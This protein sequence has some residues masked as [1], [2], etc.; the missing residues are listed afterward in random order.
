MVDPFEI[1]R[2]FEEELRRQF[3][4]DK[5]LA[6]KCYTPEFYT[7]L[8]QKFKIND[9]EQIA[10]IQEC[11]AFAAYLYLEG[12]KEQAEHAKK[13]KLA[14]IRK[15]MREIQLVANQLNAELEGLSGP[16]NDLFWS[17]QRWIEADKFFISTDSSVFGHTIVRHEFPS[18]AKSVSVLRE[19]QIREA[20]RIIG[21][22]ASAASAA[23]S[24]KGGRPADEALR[25]WVINAQ[26]IWEKILNR[27]F[28]FYEY[29]GIPATG[30]FL[31]YEM[32]LKPLDPTVTSASL[33]TAIRK[34]IKLKPAARRNTPARRNKQKPPCRIHR[35]FCRRLLLTLALR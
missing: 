32:A 10:R 19:S 12:K 9:P 22:L 13:P 15:K 31:F 26:A 6:G 29:D 7:R 3:E 34:A 33:K 35:G 17:G 14:P 30:A 2:Q 8:K 20:V 24:P 25:M 5:A 23:K 21:N 28:N 1:Q 27:T 4:Q 18:G 11:L 16:A